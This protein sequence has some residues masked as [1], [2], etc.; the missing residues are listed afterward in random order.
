MA[1][2]PL[3]RV[4]ILDLRHVHSRHLGPLFEEQEKA[5]LEQLQWDY[6]AS[7]RLI[8]KHIDARALPGYIALVGGQVAGYCFFVYEEAAVEK[9]T[10]GQKGLIGDLFVRQAYRPSPVPSGALEESGLAPYRPEAS[11]GTG[12]ATQLLEHALETLKGTPGLGRIEA[13]LMPFGIEPLLPVF[14][15]HQFRS[16]PRLFMYRPLQS[17]L[18]HR[19]TGAEEAREASAS[20]CPERSRSAPAW[21]STASSKK[22]WEIQRWD[23]RHFEA[24]AELIVSAY[25]GHI[26]SNINDQYASQTGALKF[27]KNIVIFP[28]CGVFR[29]EGS[30]VAFAESGGL[31]GALLV[32]EVAPRVAHITQVCVRRE[33]QGSGLGRQLLARALDYLHHRGYTGVSLSVTADNHPAVSLYRDSGF[34]VLKEFAAYVWDKPHVVAAR[35]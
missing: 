1:T 7:V 30:F 4:E 31:A 24:L 34:G 5:W 11:G 32:S 18:Q 3:P 26:D 14:R 6:K 27:L 23:D 8:K 19:V 9:H 35:S 12:L 25:T 22:H 15:T 29:P 17:T 28:G 20:A 33:L 13:Q 2:V 16:Y 10:S 21:G